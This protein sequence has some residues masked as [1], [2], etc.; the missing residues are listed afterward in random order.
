MPLVDTP[1]Y[2]L[3]LGEA[4]GQVGM[5]KCMLVRAIALRLEN[6][7]PYPI[8]AAIQNAKDVTTLLV[9]FRAAMLAETIADLYE[10]MKLEP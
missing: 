1:E 2:W 9:W 8:D 5:A 7:V 3:S 10:A 4:R 6:P